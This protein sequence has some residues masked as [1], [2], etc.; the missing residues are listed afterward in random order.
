MRKK[1]T[2]TPINAHL[3]KRVQGRAAH[4][5]RVAQGTAWLVAGRANVVGVR[6][7]GRARRARRGQRLRTAAT[8]SIPLTP[9]AARARRQAVKEGREGGRRLEQE[10]GAGHHG[11]GPRRSHWATRRGRRIEGPPG[12]R[13]FRW[14]SASSSSEHS[15]FSLRRRLRSE[16]FRP[17]KTP[18]CPPPCPC[19]PPCRPRVGRRAAAWPSPPCSRR[20]CP[21]PT[22]RPR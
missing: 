4:A 15:S 3:A 6:V 17:N 8:S 16:S 11:R 2:S 22:S 18:Q 14:K 5:V 21:S 13:V 12:R 1:Q 10:E 9:D 19:A 20:A 7:G